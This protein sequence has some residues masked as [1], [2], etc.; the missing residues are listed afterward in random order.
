MK[1][2]AHRIATTDAQID[3]A[4]QGAKDFAGSAADGRVH[5]AVYE[6][7]GD[8]VTLFLADGVILSIPRMY[9]QGLQ[10]GTRAQLS[11]IQVVGAGTGLHWPE[12]DADH[13]VPGLLNQVFGTKRWMSELGRAGG[14][15]RSKAKVN[16]AR[17]NGMKG[18]RPR[19]SAA[20]VSEKRK[21]TA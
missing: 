1:N 15:S 8:R 18:G 19:K 21:K 9:L 12:L 4:L 20:G 17:A 10:H 7:N 16:A 5:K 2:R 6:S 14:A 11:N 3:K 13:Y